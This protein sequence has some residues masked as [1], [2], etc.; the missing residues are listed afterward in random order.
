MKGHCVELPHYC[1]KKSIFHICAPQLKT[2][3]SSWQHETLVPSLIPLSFPSIAGFQLHLLR[4]FM[5][6]RFLC[7]YLNN[8]PLHTETLHYRRSKGSS[9][10]HLCLFTQLWP[11]AALVCQFIQHSG[12]M[13]HIM[14]FTAFR[15][16]PPVNVNMYSLTVYNHID[17][18][19][20]CCEW[21]PNP[22]YII[23]SDKVKHLIHISPS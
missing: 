15:K 13:V 7:R 8:S 23:E 4:P 18:V 1:L 14:A 2:H 6:G 11:E 16:C 20:L 12:T 17:T 5:L 10:L 19:I 21:D 3:M 9:F 22:L